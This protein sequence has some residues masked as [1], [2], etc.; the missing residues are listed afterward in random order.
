MME[1]NGLRTHERKLWSANVSCWW[2]V[3]QK[4]AEEP[5][6]FHGDQREQQKRTWLLLGGGG[7]EDGRAGSA[8]ASPSSG[9]RNE[10]LSHYT[11]NGHFCYLPL[12][13]LGKPK[14]K[15]RQDGWVLSSA[16]Y[17]C[18]SRLR[19]GLFLFGTTVAVSLEIR[20]FVQQGDSS[21]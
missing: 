21:A 8:R 14:G 1:I 15:M 20:G 18:R 9:S 3:A 11:G 6:M 7:G 10:F 5:W 12:K 19:A 13:L 16:F 17:T 4:R 2:R